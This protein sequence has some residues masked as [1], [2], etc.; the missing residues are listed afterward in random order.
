MSESYRTGQIG[1]WGAQGWRT[2]A[3]RHQFKKRSHA[4]FEFPEPV[5][6]SVREVMVDADILDLSACGARLRMSA[7]FMPFVGDQVTARL[8]DG[9]YLWGSVVWI[10]G[11]T[12][13]IVF[14]VPLRN[15]DSLRW[16]ES[17]GDA[18]LRRIFSHQKL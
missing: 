9:K 17:R 12:F 2:S 3:Q 1:F 11:D 15:L 16:P 10:E 14:P 18:Y 13:G 8:I 7:S 4:R 6:L 5:N